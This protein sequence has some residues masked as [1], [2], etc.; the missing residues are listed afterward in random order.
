MQAPLTKVPEVHDKQ[1]LLVTV[2]VVEAVEPAAAQVGAVVKEIMNHPYEQV[3][4]ELM[5]VQPVG[6]EL[7]AILAE[8]GAIAAA[9]ALVVKV[10]PDC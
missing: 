3:E 7:V 10:P 6:N 4:A 8:A 2:P 5:L 9:V 1:V